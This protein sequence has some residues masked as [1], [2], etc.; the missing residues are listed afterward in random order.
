MRK[1][2]TVARLGGDE[3]AVLLTTGDGVDG[4]VGAAEKLLEALMPP[5]ASI[6]IAWYPDHG[7]DYA[8]VLRHADVAMYEAKHG[9][10]GYVAF[11]TH[12]EGAMSRPA[13]A[14]ELTEGI[15]GGGF[16][17]RFQPK[18]G[19]RSGLVECLEVLVRWRHPERS[20]LLPDAFVPLAEQTGAS[21]GL[22]LRVL[23]MALAVPSLWRG[24]ERTIPLAINVSNRT[25]HNPG[26]A[27][28]IAT[29]LGRAGMPPQNL[30]LE[31]KEGRAHRDA[32]GERRIMQRLTDLGVVLAIDGF[33]LGY[34][35]LANLKYLPIKELKIDRSFVANAVRSKTDTAIARCLVEL[36]YSLGMHVVGQGIEN[37]ETWHLLADIG[38]DS[39]QGYLIARPMRAREMEKWLRTSGRQTFAAPART[40]FPGRAALG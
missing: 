4:A 9:E 16:E 15:A 29:R 28:E 39:A 6:G 31:V 14:S 40:L 3:F 24:A 17:L 22:C 34:S 10:S 19:I 27:D 26:L 37:E 13:L 30:I 20:L 18:V 36:G 12:L 33:G 25:L 21:W 11:E 2:D 38:C 35:S 5:G 32:E 8:T 1:S 7:L 23:D